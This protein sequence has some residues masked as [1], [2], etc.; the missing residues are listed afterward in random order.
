MLG[1]ENR[2]YA[3]TQTAKIRRNTQEYSA[4]PALRENFAKIRRNTQEYAN[5]QAI[6]IRSIFQQYHNPP[7]EYPIPGLWRWYGRMGCEFGLLMRNPKP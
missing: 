6:Q 5:T 3:N 7:P 1:W 2:E 4:N